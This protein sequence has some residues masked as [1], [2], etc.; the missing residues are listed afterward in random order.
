M[1]SFL[2]G[3]GVVDGWGLRVWFMLESKKEEGDMEVEG[4]EEWEE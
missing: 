4:E 1:F 3:V 2:Y